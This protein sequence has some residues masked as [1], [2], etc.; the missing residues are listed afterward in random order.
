MLLRFLQLTASWNDRVAAVQLARPGQWYFR[1]IF[2]IKIYKLQLVSRVK[3][4]HAS[5][6][7]TS[8]PYTVTTPMPRG[9]AGPADRCPPQQRSRSILAAQPIEEARLQTCCMPEAHGIEAAL[10]ASQT[11]G[12]VPCRQEHRASTV[13]R[14]APGHL[15]PSRVCQVN[16]SSVHVRSACLDT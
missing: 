12:N 4:K 9:A 10:E 13:D 3:I 1:F 15:G 6:Q 14:S 8:T 2:Y 11:L 7:K 16:T 5:C